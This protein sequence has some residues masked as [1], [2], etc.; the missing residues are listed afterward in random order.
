M[1]APFDTGTSHDR[2]GRY[3]EATTVEDFQHNLAAVRARIEAACQRVGRD[4]AGVR[5]LPVSKTKP[6]ASLRLAHSAG[7]RMLGEKPPTD[8]DPQRASE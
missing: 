3:P 7:C 4:P 6:E 5:L 1:R 2:H 8:A